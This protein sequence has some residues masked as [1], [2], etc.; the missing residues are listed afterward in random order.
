M[1]GGGLEVRVKSRG[2]DLVVMRVWISLR[3]LRSQMAF[4]K[5]APEATTDGLAGL[6]S[7]TAL[8]GRRPFANLE[9]K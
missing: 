1:G 8:G 9:D 3:A 2:G 5:S 6:L 4:L 7:V